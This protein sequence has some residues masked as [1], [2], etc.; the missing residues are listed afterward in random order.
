MT[1]LLQRDGGRAVCF[2][3]EIWL[4][5]QLAVVGAKKIL[6]DVIAPRT[7]GGTAALGWVSSSSSAST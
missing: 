5:A 1:S 2:R 6:V 4:P 3:Q 7:D